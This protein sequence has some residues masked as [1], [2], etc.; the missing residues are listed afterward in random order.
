MKILLVSDTHGDINCLRNTVIPKH[1]REIDLV[2]HLGDYVRDFNEVKRVFPGMIMVGVAGAY[3]TGERAERILKFGD[4]DAQQRILIMHGHDQGV[5]QGL[6]RI[7]NYAKYKDV[8][9]CFFGH[10]HEPT[11]FTRNDVFFMNPGSLTDSRGLPKCSY[12]LVN[13]SGTGEFTG[14]LVYI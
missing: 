13:I 11:I 6:G 3:E 7:A 4:G 14:E 5:K 10:T 9:A 1:M 12:G 2:I 8:H